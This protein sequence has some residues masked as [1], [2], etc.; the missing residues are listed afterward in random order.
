MAVK[1]FY[2]VKYRLKL[3]CAIVI[4]CYL[5]LFLLIPGY[6]AIEQ[7]GTY[8]SFTLG[9]LHFFVVARIHLFNK[10]VLLK[11]FANCKHL[12]YNVSEDFKCTVPDVTSVDTELDLSRFRA[13][14]SKISEVRKNM[15]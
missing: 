8:V 10:S 4:L 3:H 12:S 13:D 6:E 14:F 11:R 1:T 15:L 7:N 5:V 9:K 2:M